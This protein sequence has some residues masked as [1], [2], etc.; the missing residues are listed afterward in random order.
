M[1]DR[2]DAAAAAALAARV[3]RPVTFAYLDILSMPWRVTN[4]PYSYAFSGTGDEE[5][6]GYTFTA[7]DSRFVSVSTVKAREDGNETVTVTLSGLA[8]VDD[9]LMTLIGDKSNWQG[10]DI[11]L[12]QAMLDPDSL[13]RIGAVWAYHT[14]IMTVP[15]VT[16]DRSGQS[17]TI[18][19]ENYLAI[20][21]RASNRTYLDQRSYDPG[22]YSADLAVAIANGAGRPR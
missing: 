2:P 17:L 8:G 14:G 15:K 5:L 11:R 3:R 9:E 12:W 13:T 18:E 6:D 19:I 4:A 7:V 20:L 1:V 22:D 21:T 16:G 10:R